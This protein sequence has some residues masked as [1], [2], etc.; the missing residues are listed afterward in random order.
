MPRGALKS[1]RSPF[2]VLREVW[3]GE[4][5]PAE[6]HPREVGALRHEIHAR[7]LALQGLYS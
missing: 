7:F 6:Q 1:S 5:E 3:A 2:S 4:Y